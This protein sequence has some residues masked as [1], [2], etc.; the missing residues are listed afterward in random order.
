MTP[1]QK[2]TQLNR[3]TLISGTL[4][5]SILT[6]SITAAWWLKGTLSDMQY[7]LRDVA[8]HLAVLEARP[9]ETWGI[10]EQIDYQYEL[11]RANPT[12][13]IPDAREVRARAGR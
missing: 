2:P 8:S 7:A 11:G 6:L 1:A 5:F 9:A 3:D 10:S 13:K 4:A 12:L